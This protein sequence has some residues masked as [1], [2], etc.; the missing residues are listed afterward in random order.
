MRPSIL[1]IEGEIKSVLIT[2]R[3][4]EISVKNGIVLLKEEN[5]RE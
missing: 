3:E 5:E 1:K 2:D 4:V